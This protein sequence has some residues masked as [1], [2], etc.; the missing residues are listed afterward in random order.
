MLLALLALASQDLASEWIDRVS[1]DVLQARGP[2]PNQPLR[3][4]IH[5]GAYAAYETNANLEESDEDA[6]T[7]LSPFLRVRLDYS[8]RQ[9]DAAADILAQWKRY[10]PDHEFSDDEERVYGRVRFISPRLSLEAA[11][12]FQH[13][14]DPVDAV[15]ADRVD[16]L[17]S[18]TVG[19]A[20]FELTPA[21]ALEAD[22][23]LGIV[24]FQEKSFDEGDNWNLR[25]GLGLAVR[26]SA[27]LEAVAEGGGFLIDYRYETGAPPD[28]DGLFA[29]GGI[30]GD[31]GTS[32]SATI[33][34]GV[35]RA[36]SEDY[37]SGLEGEE[38]ETGEAA[39]RLR[40]EAS[41]RLTLHGDYT[42]IFAFA[43]ATDPFQ[44]VNRWI[45]SAE[46]EATAE[47]RLIGRLQFDHVDGASGLER[48]YASV[49]G[50][51]RWKSHE[52]V[53]FDAGLIYRFGEVSPGDV[54]YDDWIVQFGVV[55]TN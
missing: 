24:R 13:V 47:L 32:V 6:E 26:L 20:R 22:L 51:A 28:V 42:R 35:A 16:R 53:Y 40:W 4:T 41:D 10:I 3:H 46:W 23:T 2:L 44:V 25:G 37:D 17:L 18:D 30:R 39:V 29:R 38:E 49:G 43:V 27:A 8:E 19:R 50:S 36:E 54:E 34:A 11:E 55:I 21:V 52:Q 5:M 45:A 33:L 31:F 7:I 12:I 1:R 48:D 9:V 14:S 15:F